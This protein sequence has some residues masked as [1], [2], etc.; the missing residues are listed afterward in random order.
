LIGYHARYLLYSLF[1]LGTE[2]FNEV[3]TAVAH[4]ASS[5]GGRTLQT[6]DCMS[7]AILALFPRDGRF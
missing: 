2:D 6:A 7:S 1:F 3:T 4:R 5:Q